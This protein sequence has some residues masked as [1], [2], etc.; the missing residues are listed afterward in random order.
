[1]LR[2]PAIDWLIAQT[3]DESKP[4]QAQ[5]TNSKANPVTGSAE[6]PAGTSSVASSR[7]ATANRILT[8]EADA[9]RRMRRSVIQPVAMDVRPVATN[10]RDPK[11]PIFAM[12]MWR[13]VT[14][15]EGIQL[16][17]SAQT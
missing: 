15:Y 6:N 10:S 4:K 13:S 7:P 3:F 2:G 12:G 16:S 8:F 14:R 5:A 17:I 1:M 11:I 9:P